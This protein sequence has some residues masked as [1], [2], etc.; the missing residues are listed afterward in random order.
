VVKLICYNVEYC[1]G[2]E[3]F[4]YQ[5]LEFWKILF[6]PKNLDKQIVKAVKKLKPDIFAMVEV[7][8]GSFRSRGKDE[9][10]FFEKELE[11]SNFV[12]KV[13]YPFQSW[14]KLFHYVPILKKQSNAIVSKYKISKVKYHVFHEGT[15]RVII[16]VTVKCPKKVTLLLCHLALG[17]GTRSAQID[18][19]VDLVNGIK[20][21]VILMGDFNT[22]NGP[23]EIQKLL[24]KTHLQ[25]KSK[26]DK[27]SLMLTEPTAHPVRRLDYVLTSDRIKVKKYQ[28]LN[29]PF[30][31]HMPLFVEFNVK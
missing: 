13:K 6:P 26:L 12:E 20:N 27:Y 21:P 15:K 28:V 31:D 10:K 11:M 3:G 5:Y 29:F 18:E 24:K 4:W 30:S 8:A 22:F 7:D 23:K 19:L 25:D 1:E 17:G 16:E 2:I 9:V 14:L